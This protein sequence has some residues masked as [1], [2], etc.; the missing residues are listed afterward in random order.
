MPARGLS[1]R[2]VSDLLLHARASNAGAIL[3]VALPRVIREAEGHDEEALAARLLSV[4]SDTVRAHVEAGTREVSL[5]GGV[6]SAALCAM[7]ARHAPGQVRAWTMDVH[8]ADAVERSNAQRMAKVTGAELVDVIIPDAV[9][10]DLFE[11]AVL[12][13]QT[14]I[15]N[16]RAV[17]SSVFYLEA[18]RQ[19]AG[20][21]LLSG[22]G[23]DE[24]LKGTPGVLASAKARVDEDRALAARVLAPVDNSWAPSRAG[25][26]DHGAARGAVDN[27]GG[28]RSEALEGDQESKPSI[29]SGNH[30]ADQAVGP[31]AD[32]TPV[33][34]LRTV[35]ES[36]ND[37]H[38]LRAPPVD[39]LGTG[40][41]APWELPQEDALPT[42]ELRYAQWVLAELIL[43]PELRGARAHGLTVRTPYL[44]EGFAR[45]ALALPESV[46]LRDGF[47]KWLFRHAVRALVPNEVRLAR[48][49]PRYGHTALSSPVRS[50]WLELYRAWL[51]P[52]RLEPLQVIDSKAVLGLLERYV[53][54]PADDPRAGP[55][56]RLLM[57][58]MS[59]AMLQ[60]HTK[61]P[62]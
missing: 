49:T 31:R 28:A 25:S 42:E 27:S 38:A 14:A 60:A 24:V 35:S 2:A 52:A 8:F 53:R 51:S 19:G 6:D 15:L 13:N 57:R 16:A 62:P 55:M 54:L 44:D 11:H 40:L 20:P 33:D 56:D 34:N 45:V 46:L 32:S 29:P 59:L 30:G 26:H 18:R 3:D 47:G 48:K 5:S 43:P 4:W 37:D 23:A 39:N 7:A 36:G 61:A 58:L 17:A 9:L 21:V 50:R 12:A 41:P 22:A 10:P 1:L